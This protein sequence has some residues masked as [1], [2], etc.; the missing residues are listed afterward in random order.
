MYTIIYTPFSNC[1]IIR[2]DQSTLKFSLRRNLDALYIASRRSGRTLIL[3][4]MSYVICVDSML[5][6]S[7]GE[8]LGCSKI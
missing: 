6:V 2:F 3:S 4:T 8:Y 7:T 1:L 5:C